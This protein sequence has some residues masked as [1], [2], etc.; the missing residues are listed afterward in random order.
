MFREILFSTLNKKI[1]VKG[2]FSLIVR[3]R[4]L[5]PLRIAVHS[6]QPSNPYDKE[7]TV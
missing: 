5:E 7:E 2:D 4:G 1:L 6:P 3:W